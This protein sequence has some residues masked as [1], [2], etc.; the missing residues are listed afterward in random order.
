MFKILPTFAGA[1]PQ[2]V[3]GVSRGWLLIIAALGAWA[4]LIVVVG[5]A[6]RLAEM[7]FG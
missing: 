6:L 5:V 7:I 4:L 3:I 1:T 2:P